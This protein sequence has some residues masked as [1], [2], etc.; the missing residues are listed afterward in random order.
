MSKK[1]FASLGYDLWQI[2]NEA[3]PD[4]R[5]ISD[6]DAF[7]RT[8]PTRWTKKEILAHLIDSATNNHQRFVR[9]AEQKGGAFPSYNQDLLQKLQRSNEAEWSLVI[10]LWA[11]YNRYL[12]HILSG[13][14]PE[15]QECTCTV[16][17]SQPMTL[18]FVAED[19]VEHL[20]H[21][22]NQIL[23]RRWQ[24]TYSAK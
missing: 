11:S 1:T 17:D 15:A 23:G 2:V 8:S 3:E 16:G 20:K 10:T 14:P 7:A 12:A 24:S 4:L 5:R 18:L 19:Y 9:G 22:L 21:H 6:M 13:L